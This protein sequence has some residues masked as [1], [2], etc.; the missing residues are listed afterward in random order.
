MTVRINP[1]TE[2]NQRANAALI[3]ALGVVDT[4]RFLSQFR[5]SAGDYTKERQQLFG[6]MTT[7]SII[8][9][10]KSRRSAAATDADAEPA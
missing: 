10:I 7:T 8:A 1:I 9:E 3:D 4:I 6:D 5:G 2:V